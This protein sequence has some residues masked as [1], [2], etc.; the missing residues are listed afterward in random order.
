MKN[1]ITSSE[2]EKNSRG[3]KVLCQELVEVDHM[4]RVW[5]QVGSWE[6][7]YPL[8][9][10]VCAHPVERLNSTREGSPSTSSVV[11][12]VGREWQESELIDIRSGYAYLFL[13]M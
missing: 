10:P 12:H 4:T 8:E 2:E 6:E 11:P 3:K 7:V 13:Q 1:A 5:V 9:A